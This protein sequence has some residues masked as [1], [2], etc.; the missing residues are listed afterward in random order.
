MS[1]SIE[2]LAGQY[3]QA[4]TDLDVDAIVALHTED[5]VFHLHGVTDAA[6]GRASIRRV[7][8]AM[9]GLVPDLHF[10]AKRAYLGADHLVLEYDM[11][12]TVGESSFVCDGADVI[13]VQD[14]LV[15]R[16]DTYL[17]LAA[18]QRQAGAIPLLATSV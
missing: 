6:T 18:Y 2:E 11:S 16:K 15:A 4:W 3:H 7:I 17:D 9:L 5:S 13:A 10:D 1:L 8:V 12:G 14:G